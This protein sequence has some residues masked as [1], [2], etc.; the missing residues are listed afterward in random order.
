MLVS[1]VVPIYN[2][3]KFINLTV[4][5]LKNQ[6]CKDGQQLEFILINDGSTDRT[7]EILNSLGLESDS[8]FRIISIDNRGYGHACNLGVEMSSGDY[9]SIFE[10]DDQ[11]DNDFYS[12][13]MDYAEKFPEADLLR[14]RGLLQISGNTKKTLYSWKSEITNRLLDVLS[15]PHI[16]KSHTS[17][18]NGM[19]R[20]NFI[21]DNGIKF[22]ETP[23]ASYQ[24]V[25]FMVSLYYVKPKIL[26]IDDVKYTY[27]CH[28]A[29]SVKCVSDRIQY[30][31]QNWIEEK[32]WLVERGIVDF[33][34]F[35]YRMVKQYQSILKKNPNL[36]REMIMRSVRRLLNNRCI[37]KFPPIVT[38]KERFSWY[39]FS[40]KA[41]RFRRSPRRHS[42]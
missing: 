10:P 16:W 24:D 15:N 40:L 6:I 31:F 17:V 18:F 21:V 33:S 41:R 12:T 36:D 4:T 26:I 30:V 11:I 13:L 3:E 27:V 39:Y 28:E 32:K 2:M 14:Y 9:V 20:R 25:T 23:L 7:F 38:L 1:V 19:Y 22:C 5:C 37:K 42:S 34:F 8:R 35:N 29:Q